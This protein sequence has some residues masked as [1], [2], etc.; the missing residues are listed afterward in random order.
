VY[1]WVPAVSPAGLVFYGGDRFKDWQGKVLLVGMPEEALIVITLNGDKVADEKRYDMGERIR[2]VI[3]APDGS[4]LLLSDGDDAELWR[5][6][7]K[8]EAR[9]G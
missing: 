7:P 9:A 5:L 3:E 4:V 6:T 1:A 2:D 8:G